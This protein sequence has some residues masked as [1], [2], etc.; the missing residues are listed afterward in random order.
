MKRTLLIAAVTTALVTSATAANAAVHPAAAHKTAVTVSAS[1]PNLCI[2]AGDQGHRRTI[3]PVCGMPSMKDRVPSIA[4]AMA[5]LADC[6][7]VYAADV[8]TPAIARWAAALKPIRAHNALVSVAI[9]QGARTATSKAD[10]RDINS[11]VGSYCQA[12]KQYGKMIDALKATAFTGVTITFNGDTD[13]SAII[14][15]IDAGVSAARGKSGYDDYVNE[16]AR[17]RSTLDQATLAQTLTGQYAA[18][19]HLVASYNTV[20]SSTAKMDL[21]DYVK[22]HSAVLD[23][24]HDASDLIDYAELALG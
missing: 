5:K 7:S 1:K 11:A 13:A 8:I 15:A 23:A 18:L 14:S 9:R 3:K 16:L 4:G 12:A 19:D 22:A 21:N 17:I 20:Y 24:V 10:I 6:N 2:F